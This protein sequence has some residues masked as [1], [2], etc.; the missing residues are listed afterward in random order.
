LVVIMQRHAKEIRQSAACRL[1]CCS[2]IALLVGLVG[3][4]FCQ[5]AESQPDAPR[6]ALLVGCT[7]YPECSTIPELW[8]PANDIPVIAQLLSEKF[9]IPR[10]HIQCLVGW[11]DD[12]RARPTCGNITRAFEDLIRKSGP[13]VQSVIVMNGHGV[14]MPIPA[15]QVDALDAANP[16]HDGFDEVFLPADVEPWSG[17][18]LKN[19]IR[20]D[21][22]ARWLAA[23][24]RRGA[25]VWIVFDCC[26]SGTMTRAV[27]DVERT[28]GVNARDLGVPASRVD[29]ALRKAESV[30][31]KTR[32]G[33][34][35]GENA[36]DL[37]PDG[38]GPGS[39]IAFY[40]AQPFE[41]AKEL[42][43]PRGSPQ[44]PEHYFGLFSYIMTQALQQCEGSLTYR[45]L[46]Q[47][48]ISRYRA[49]R[50]S[51][52]PTPSFEGD[53]DRQ[54]L[55]EQRIRRTPILLHKDDSGARLSAGTLGGVTVGSV[56]AVYTA[57]DKTN[58]DA[59][60]VGFVR[61]HRL[62][63]MHADVESVAHQGSSAV[64]VEALPDAAPCK[65]VSQQLGD[66][67]LRVAIASGG[68][69]G[70]GASG[71]VIAEALRLLP[72][73]SA[74]LINVIEN[75]AEAEW[76]L[77]P[78]SGE[79]GIG[80]AT[81]GVSRTTVLLLPGSGQQTSRSPSAPAESSDKHPTQAA[82]ARR[83]YRR[84]PADDPQKLAAAL[85]VD[86]RK[87]YA[88]QNLWRIAQSYSADSA[89]VQNQDLQLEVT[90][91]QGPQDRSRGTRLQ[92]T[93]LEP[94]D[95]VALRL[96]N[97]GYQP[98]WYTVLFLDANFGIWHVN[99][100][101]INRGDTSGKPTELLVERMQVEGDSSGPEGY[102]VLS[103]PI[104]Q[105]RQQP[106]FQFLAQSPLGEEAEPGTRATPSP[107]RT[108]FEHVLVNLRATGGGTRGGAAESPDNPCISSWSWV[109]VCQERDKR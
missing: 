73:E 89:L 12:P 45:D 35:G 53:L 75:E 82:G 10:P 95:C 51:R 97:T 38:E 76:I 83:V 34:A 78:V 100:G 96:V 54:V 13:G 81:G 1:A 19:A 64:P 27:S 57:A 67:R 63:A 94:G 68:P 47:R 22:I 15:E 26:H 88:W 50:G 23:M 11:P 60:P 62:G 7:K 107:P 16:E 29:A 65:L 14:Q 43:R 18:A 80:D 49:E 36:L 66:L 33:A 79:Q 5:A 52:P 86:F 31:G 71:A 32:G 55:G 9:A 3:Q 37:S 91:L 8:G 48:I 99:S 21:Q 87:I 44:T 30:P 24:K 58:E 92:A 108:P 103:I 105:Q 74:L 109:T 84:Y 106:H 104:R 69:S 4:P 42:P 61:V 72:A 101:S 28:R 102:L 25:S 56:F 90:R 17:D 6:Y 40:A 70:G 85:S 2:A 41:K 46:T 20:D 77:Q 98:L 39:V 93:S 59:D